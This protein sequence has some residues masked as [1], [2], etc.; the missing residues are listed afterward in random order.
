LQK[1]FCGAKMAHLL[2]TRVRK[3]ALRS[4]RSSRLFSES[5]ANQA[6]TSTSEKLKSVAVPAV[7]LSSAGLAYYYS[8]D[9]CKKFNFDEK[10]DSHRF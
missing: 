8:E 10:R 7:L 6:N 2:W 1:P 9:I 3:F 5:S 4:N